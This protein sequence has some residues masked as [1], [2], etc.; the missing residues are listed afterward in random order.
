MR[1]ADTKS[2]CEELRSGHPLTKGVILANL[3]RDEVFDAEIVHIASNLLGDESMSIYGRTV[4]ELAGYYLSLSR[5]E[6]LPF[7]IKPMD[8]AKAALLRSS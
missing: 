6:R 7:E 8:P 3:M 2:I 1:Q 5:G 4:A